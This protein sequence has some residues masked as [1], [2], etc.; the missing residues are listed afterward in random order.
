MPCLSCS[1]VASTFNSMAKGF[2][3]RGDLLWCLLASTGPTEELALYSIL[4]TALVSFATTGDKT[5]AAVMT[6]R[7]EAVSTDSNSAPGVFLP[8]ARGPENQKSGHI[9]LVT[10]NPGQEAVEK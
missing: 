5:V 4:Q 2:P 10:L 9:G 1:T 7:H 3:C 6:C 8:S